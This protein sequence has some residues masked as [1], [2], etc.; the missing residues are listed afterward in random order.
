[1]RHLHHRPAH[2]LKRSL[3]FMIDLLPIQAALYI[4]CV[5]AFDI[6]PMADPVLDRPEVQQAA[7]QAK[8]AIAF[9]N[10]FIWILY[11]IVAELS[12]WKGTLGKKIMGIQV[13]AAYG[14]KLTFRQVVGRNLAKILSALPCYLGF[15]WALLTHGNRAWHDMLSGTAV[16]E[17]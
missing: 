12:P 1:M 11:C 10:L 3:A 13:K 9:G 14:G 4:I 15:M 8:Y 5:A 2:G 7:A 6:R 17:N 16:T